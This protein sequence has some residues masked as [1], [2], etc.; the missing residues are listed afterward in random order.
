LLWDGYAIVVSGRRVSI[1]QYEALALHFI[2]FR[3]F[4]VAQT[5]SSLTGHETA[6][7]SSSEVWQCVLLRTVYSKAIRDGWGSEQGKDTALGCC[8][9]RWWESLPIFLIHA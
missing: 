5:T 1:L 7:W 4:R 2:G 3:C 9:P 8:L 6:H